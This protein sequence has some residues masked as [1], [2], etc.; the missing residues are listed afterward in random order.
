MP[1]ILILIVNSL[2]A[3]ELCFN[4]NLSLCFSNWTNFKS[5]KGG[6]ALTQ[7]T[8]QLFYSKKVVTNH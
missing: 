4:L 7:S 2:K 5:L 6:H 8:I 1:L 3:F